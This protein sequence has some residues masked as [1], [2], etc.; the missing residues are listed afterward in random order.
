MTVTVAVPGTFTVPDPGDIVTE[1]QLTCVQ[2]P[3]ENVT[4]L[5][6]PPEYAEKARAYTVVAGA[7]AGEIENGARS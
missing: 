6:P 3:A 5:P 2:G 7:N 1:V 4:L